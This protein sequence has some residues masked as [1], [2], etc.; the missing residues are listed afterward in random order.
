MKSTADGGTYVMLWPNSLY[1]PD[2]RE[3]LID[4][5]QTYE[6][7]KIE[8]R[9]GPHNDMVFHKDGVTIK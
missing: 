4:V 5:V 1:V 3:P 6:E 8:I 2:L 9:F 7:R